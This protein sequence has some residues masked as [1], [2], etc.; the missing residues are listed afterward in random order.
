[1]TDVQS[2]IV[3]VGV[4]MKKRNHIDEWAR[5]LFF[6]QIQCPCRKLLC[7]CVPFQVRLKLEKVLD[8]RAE[9]L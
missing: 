4:E 5:A 9:K 3:S 8:K 2:R 7:R 6:G 1:M